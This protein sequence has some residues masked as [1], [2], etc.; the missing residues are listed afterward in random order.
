MGWGWGPARAAA[1]QLW[2][3]VQLWARHGCGCGCKFGHRYRCG[4]RY[5]FG[6]GHGG[7]HTRW[8]CSC[9]LSRGVTH[10]VRR[11]HPFWAPYMLP[12][13]RD[14]P[15]ASLKHS[16]GSRCFTPTHR[17]LQPLV[18]AG[19]DAHRVLMGLLSNKA[20]AASPVEPRSIRGHR[21]PVGCP[22]PC[23]Q[24][25]AGRQSCH[26]PQ[27]RDRGVPSPVPSCFLPPSP[28]DPAPA[29]RLVPSTTSP[30]T[31][32]APYPG[33]LQLF[34]QPHSAWG[35]SQGHVCSRKP[36]RTAAERLRWR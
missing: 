17:P 34:P 36:E 11:L 24:H 22:G 15:G 33:L 3:W 16:G 30:Q 5:R 1:G 7:S 14:P 12:H 19:L 31:P 28:T 8:K 9:W 6:A 35:R 4:R 29:P 10:W 27:D 23:S 20:T 26:Q 13:P 18:P 32:V 21:V 25:P 2:P